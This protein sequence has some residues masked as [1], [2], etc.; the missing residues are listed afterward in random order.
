MLTIILLAY[1]FYSLDAGE[2]LYEYAI[3]VIITVLICYLL[4]RIETLSDLSSP[5]N[6]TEEV[7]DNRSAV[8][9]SSAKNIGSLLK[10]YCEEPQLYLQHDISAMQ[11]AKLIGTNRLYLSKHFA[12]QGITYSTYINGLRIQHFINLYH[13]AVATHQPITV[14]QLAHKSG[15]HSYSTFNSAFKQSMGMTASEW[16][17]SES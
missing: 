12:S 15:F 14:R 2:L 10:Q 6:D 1:A 4:W 5:V 17:S 9:A 8:V 3:E 16:M 7:E 13:E 11:L